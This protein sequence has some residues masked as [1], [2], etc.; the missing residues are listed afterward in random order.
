[1]R[2]FKVIILFFLCLASITAWGQVDI[3]NLQPI[4]SI[5][6]NG[7]NPMGMP[8]SMLPDSTNTADTSAEGPKGIVYHV[9]IPD[10]VLQAKVFMFHL[11]PAQVKFNQVSHPILTPTGAQFS[12]RL[13]GMN[14]NYYLT[15]TELGHP[16][17]SLFPSFGSSPG[18]VYK[19]NVFPG[20]Y[21]TPKNITLYQV[22]TPYTLLSY[23][24]SLDKDYQ[25]HVTHSQNINARWN[26]A[27]DY[28]LISPE[29]VFSNS[30]ATDH[31]LDLTTNYY[32]RDARYQVAAGFIWQRM[33]VGENGGLSN[34]DIYTNKR[35]SSLSGVPV[36]YTNGMSN[37][38]DHT[39]FVRQTFNTVRQFEWYRPIKETFIDTIP[40]RDTLTL[41]LF[42]T[43]LNDSVAVDTVRTTF[44]YEARDSIV[45][46]DTIQPHDPHVYNTG[47]LG[48]ELQWDRQKY[49]YRD[50]TL[51]NK[52][53]ATLFW[54]NDAYLDRRW[55]NPLKLYG[56]LRPEVAWLKQDSSLY[57][58]TSIR[59]L[60]LYPF[61][62]LEISPWPAAE[63]ILYAEA[64]P[65]LSEY[66]LDARLQ[67][68]FR[69]SN[70][71]STQNLTFHAVVKA[72]QPELIYIAQNYLRKSDYSIEMKPI[73]IRQIEADYK[74]GDFLQVHLA[75][76]HISHNVWFEQMANT[77][78]TTVLLP[79]QADGSALLLQG[80]LNLNLKLTGWL[81][82]D[83]Q[84]H[85]QYSSDQDQIRVPL[86]ATK[87]SVY[88][89]F[90]LFH[91]VLHTQVGVDVRYHTA[92]KAD[93]YDPVLGAF[94]RQ[95]DVEVGN[96][97]WADFFINLQVK[98]ASIYAKAAHLNS[99]LEEHSYFMLPNYP[100]KQFGF[101]F[102][103]T[104]KFFD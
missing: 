35:T 53:S 68:P 85:L 30:G 64:A 70:G 41:T 62:R 92:Y 75:A 87:N 52:L 42:D 20:L 33:L 90:K 24:S 57:S 66:N 67:F 13:D 21:K 38:R 82:Y 54:T 50:S 48:M 22:Q 15:V 86:F 78:S 96:Y 10:S 34:K 100:S 40:V 69:D 60:A 99:F 97:L 103:I 31:F 84:H 27:M 98:R 59:K 37:T 72:H 5:G 18:L 2:P 12:D 61:A 71:F 47:V 28:H 104:W 29:G 83:M 7:N 43:T 89:D 81:H 101:F 4:P 32:S 11:V 16:H 94:F 88:A 46:Y 76:Q 49:R 93:G 1:M 56:G 63:L 102:G 91:N 74:R 77:D 55:H 19:T 6:T 23:N 8:P 25:V 26:V 79:N 14:G 73:G 39:V 9:D 17:L 51:Y 95:N 36:N 44:R 65:N 3:N 45:D 80:R 58:D